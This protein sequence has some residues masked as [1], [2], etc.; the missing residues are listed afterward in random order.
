[1]TDSILLAFLSEMA[2]R[3]EMAAKN[4]LMAAGGALV[5]AILTFIVTFTAFKA[6]RVRKVPPRATMLLST[7][8]GL[9]AGWLVWAWVSGGL[10]FGPGGGGGVAGSTAPNQG[11]TA[12]HRDISLPTH[13]REPAD[14][15]RIVLVRS[16]DY[17]AESKRYYLPEGRQPAR[18]L[19]EIV[20][21]I[22]EKQQQ[23]PTLKTIEVV[24]YQDSI[25]ETRGLVA[26]LEDPVRP[27]GLTIKTH[28]PG[29][30]SP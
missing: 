22:K 19:S 27:L 21:H 20:Q 11:L 2:Q 12:T 7:V 18:N 10:G 4:A 9:L 13:Q 25:A 28:K 26:D 23:N 8:G 1:M 3:S 16:K 15:L 24:V 29:T 30:I 6:A 17:D 5:G 14:T